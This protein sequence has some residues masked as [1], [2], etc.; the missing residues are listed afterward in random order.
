MLR[1]QGA[2]TS[3][4]LV[5]TTLYVAA[6]RTPDWQAERGT[7]N[8]KRETVRNECCR[9]VWAPCSTTLVRVDGC[10]RTYMEEGGGDRGVGNKENEA[11]GV[12]NRDTLNDIGERL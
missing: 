7:S 11:L 6:I 9:G 2:D 12:Y 10:Q 1:E 3:T 5:R 8:V 4:F